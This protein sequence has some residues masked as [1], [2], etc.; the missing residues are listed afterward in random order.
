M[1]HGG[2]CSYPDIT[3]I[4]IMKLHLQRAMLSLLF[5]ISPVFKIAAQDIDSIE[6]T[7]NKSKHDTL[8]LNELLLLA[9]AYS[10]EDPAKALSYGHR[11]AGLADELDDPSKAGWAYNY[12]GSTY[13]YKG[14]YDSALYYHTQALNIRQAIQDKKGL[15]ASYNNIGNIY[16]DQGKSALALDYYFKA[17][18]YFEEVSFRRGEGIVYNSIGNLYYV[19]KKF[20]LALRYFE[21]SAKLQAELGNKVELMHVYNN[22]ALINDE[23]KDYDAALKYYHLSLDLA[24]ETGNTSAVVTNLNNMGQ[25]YRT[26]KDHK[27][28]EE[29]L[30]RAIEMGEKEDDKVKLASPYINLGK[31]FSDNKQ[32]D[33]AIV[34]YHK[35]LEIGKET[36]VK[37]YMKEAY[38]SLA[39]AWYRKGDIDKT[40]E[41][42]LLYEAMKDSLFNEESSRQVTEMATKYDTEK[43]EQQIALL[44]KDK[45]HERTVRNF[46]ISGASV[47][48]VFSLFLYRAYSGTRRLNR[49]LASQKS[50]ILQKNHDLHSKNELIQRQKQEITDSINY[51]RNI[52]Q[53]ILPSMEQVRALM[54]QSFVLY[55]PKDI[56]SGDFYWFREKS[57]CI[58]F[59]AAD[60]T[61]HGVPGGFMSMIGVEMLN[62]ALKQTDDPGMLLQLLNCSVKTALNQE[63][64]G[65]IRDGMDI[66]LCMLNG[67]R[68][69]YSG[70][71]RP[72]FIVKKNDPLEII[73]LK[74]EKA[75]IGGFTDA[76]QVFG[77]QSIEVEKGDMIYLFSDGYADQ[78]GG[79]AGKKILVKR[80]REQVV[81]AFPL[82]VNDQQALFEQAILEWMG[83]Y[84]QVDDMLVIGIRV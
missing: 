66:A 60:S 61:G 36:G 62:E 74:P 25:M 49:V 83:D 56:V 43:K 6:R 68:L 52:Q 82:P 63:R 18:K 31:L 77:V 46:I 28:A 41:Y 51:A 71:N 16:D 37:L 64:E 48:L 67:N 19:Q 58:Y 53:A 20:D 32:Y 65:A 29:I 3:D 34:Y 2:L 69:Q 72:A 81:K 5:I 14:D 26:I 80:F 57:G 75:A 1:K 50:E 8:L 23:K 59:A 17:L 55:R 35:G 39:D 4:C 73:E 11:A 42:R 45:A 33:S 54:P 9:K 76:A 84:E 79:P 44:E 27:K 7:L 10:Y 24:E 38:E 13:Y 21:Q 12:I 22:I 78:F 70:A 30:R 40:Y 15:G 47:M